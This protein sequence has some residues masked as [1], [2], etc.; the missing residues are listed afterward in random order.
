MGF[1]PPIPG[2]TPLDD[3]SGLRDRTITTQAALNAAEAE[4]IRKAVLKYLVDKPTRRS[5]RFDVR[6]LKSLHGELFGDVWMWVGQWRR[7]GANIGSDPHMIETDLADLLGG[8]S[9]WSDHGMP[10]LE[11]SVRLHHG[12]VRIHP[13]QNGN[14]RWSRMVGNI[15]LRV[16][17]HPIVEWPEGSIGSVNPVRAMYLD[18]VRRADRHDFSPLIDLHRAHLAEG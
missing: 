5:A 15:W 7:A 14:G 8:L 4:N 18:A 6:W 11:Q 12:A 2:Q 3:I 10:L 16:N 9:S 17:G 13:F 1:D